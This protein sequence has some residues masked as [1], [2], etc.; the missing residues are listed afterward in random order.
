V[1]ALRRSIFGETQSTAPSRF[2]SDIPSI[3][4]HTKGV[5]GSKSI[6][7][8]SVRNT[9]RQTDWDDD[10]QDP[11]GEQDTGRVFGRGIASPPARD[12]NVNPSHWSTTPKAPGM[13]QPGSSFTSTPKVPSG[14]TFSSSANRQ[15][16]IKGQ[17]FTP[18]DRVRHNRF[19]EGIILKSEMEGDTEFV[20]VQF[21]GSLGKKRLSMDFANLEKL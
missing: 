21:K 11:Y 19:G 9:R 5:T 10:N 16:K 8:K 12:L 18:G 13:S 1:R 4:L 3:L 17:Q 6:T 15:K 7:Q 2:L 14:P 20:E